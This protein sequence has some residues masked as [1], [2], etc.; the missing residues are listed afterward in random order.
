MKSE[1]ISEKWFTFRRLYC[2]EGYIDYWSGDCS[3]DPN[4]DTKPNYN[5][6]STISMF[7]LNGVGSW[8]DKNLLRG[9]FEDINN[10]SDGFTSDELW[11]MSHINSLRRSTGL[12]K[13]ICGRAFKENSDLESA[14]NWLRNNSSKF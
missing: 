9:L 6:N 12:N 3:N 10:Y 14:I 8:I 5:L 1:L 13:E 11:E 4:L 2:K 7:R